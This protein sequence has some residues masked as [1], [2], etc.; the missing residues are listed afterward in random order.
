MKEGLLLVIFLMISVSMSAQHGIEL[1]SGSVP[2]PG[3]QTNPRS[4][5][6]EVTASIDGQV[7]TVSFS[8]L[9]ASQIVVKDSA[10]LTVF[11]QTYSTAYSAQADLTSI[12]SGHYTLYIYAMGEWWY[13]VFELE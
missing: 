13:G 10:S 4:I 3:E 2:T 12:V 5:E 11:N 6:C 1:K 8:E 9:T 7:I